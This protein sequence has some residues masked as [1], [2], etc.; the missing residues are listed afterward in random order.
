MSFVSYFLLQLLWYLSWQSSL[1]GRT[2][3]KVTFSSSGFRNRHE[4]YNN[5]EGASNRAT[6]LTFLRDI[7]ELILDSLSSLVPHPILLL[8]LVTCWQ[9]Y[10]HLTTT[11]WLVCLLATLNSSPF[12]LKALYWTFWRLIT[13]DNPLAG[14]RPFS[15]LGLLTLFRSS[16]L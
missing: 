14:T 1:Y 7:I 8:S 12:T 4:R 3:G 13:E 11:D 6:I 16:P 2:V 10:Y 5:R 9:A 15:T